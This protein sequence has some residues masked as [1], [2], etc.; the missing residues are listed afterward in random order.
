MFD[1]RVFLN[2]NVFKMQGGILLKKIVQILNNFFARLAAIFAFLV[3]VSSTLYQY[4]VIGTKQFNPTSFII[5]A[6]ISFFCALIVVLLIRKFQIPSKESKPIELSKSSEN[7]DPEIAVVKQMFNRIGSSRS[8]MRYKD[9]EDNNHKYSNISRFDILDYNCANYQSIR[10]FHGTNISKSISSYLPYCESTEFRIGFD[11]ITIVAYDMLTGRKLKV[12]CANDSSK[13]KLCT[14]CFRINFEKPLKPGESF[15]ICYYISFPYELHC[16]SQEKEIM[17][18]S[19]VRLKKKPIDNLFFSILLNFEPSLVR[20]FSYNKNN[21]KSQTLHSNE[22]LRKT[23]LSS[24]LSDIISENILRKLP[25]DLN[26][27]FYEMGINIPKAKQ[28]MYII[29]YQN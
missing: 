22:K 15:H 12:E 3:S 13:E 14:H 21:E 24:C 11:D 16:L 7:K 18:I 17:S 29:E 6:A 2:S 4:G 23:G 10:V 25:I 1:L 28:S 8:L 19:L 9:M 26:Q 27:E 20:F 5:I